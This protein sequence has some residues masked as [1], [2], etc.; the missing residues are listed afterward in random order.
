MK[1][2]LIFASCFLFFSQT[3][4]QL[5]P[6]KLASA[7]ASL[8][9]IENCTK[10]HAVKKQVSADNCLS[11]HSLLGERIAQKQGLHANKNYHVCANCHVEHQGRD[12]NLVYW[13]DG[14]EKFNHALTGYR[15][16]G[17]HVRLKC[18]QCHQEK[19]IVNKEKL[20]AGKKDLN[21]TFLGLDQKCLSCHEDEHRGQ[22]KGTCLSCHDM[23][24]WKPANKFDHQAA[25]F[26]LSGKHKDVKCEKCHATVVDNKFSDDKE[27]QKFAGIDFSNCTDCHQDAHNNRFG[28]NCQNC[29][30][31][32]G[33]KQVNRQ[34]FDHNRTEYPLRG[35]HTSLN[36]DQ[37]H[38]PGK[39]LKIA[40]FRKC[41]DCHADY[42][43]GDFL[44]RPQHGDCEECHSVEGFEPSKFTVAK[45]NQ[46]KFAL[47]GAHLAVPC[48]ACHIK[49]HQNM[50]NETMRFK[51]RWIECNA[52]HKNPHGHQV[53]KYLTEK[54]CQNCHSILSWRKINFDHN[55]TNFPLKGAHEK[56]AC[57]KCHKPIK[58]QVD[59]KLYQFSPLAAQCTNCHKDIHYGQFRESAAKTSIT[60]C[61]RCHS[62]IDWLADK[63]QHNRD[64]RFKIDGAHQYVT[65]EQCH[66]KVNL[67]GKTFRL[68]KLLRTDCKFC[69]GEGGTPSGLKL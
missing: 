41:K 21:H 12:Y 55:T 44:H 33:W 65:C 23:K 9:G 63:F 19:N 66:P 4:A 27:F 8:E 14:K 11:C 60:R 40:H 10:C 67:K 26:P 69:H 43:H 39:P 1:K 35:R 2:I 58:N 56:T 5:S 6:G 64:A 68:F 15:L 28:Q 38:L 62:P 59:S 25:R 37:C 47:A 29:H 24:A 50:A 57:S 42:H 34:K 16:E 49:Q 13:K 53:D 7:H 22:M 17:K 30:S 54:G 45:H 18:E 61:D 31:T 20:L 48:N 32:R 3:F 36:C 46:S 51:F 52:C